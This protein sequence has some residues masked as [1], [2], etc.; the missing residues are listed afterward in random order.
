MQKKCSYLDSIRR[1]EEPD[2]NPIEFDDPIA[3]VEIH[4]T[5]Q[6]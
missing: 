4:P 3:L 2:I 5:R 1:G 6:S